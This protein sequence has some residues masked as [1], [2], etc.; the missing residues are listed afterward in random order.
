MPNWSGDFREENRKVLAKRYVYL[1]Q[2]HDVAWA[3]AIGAV[4]WIV[5]RLI[6]RRRT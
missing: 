3:V 1:I 2:E 6:E 4:G 5:G